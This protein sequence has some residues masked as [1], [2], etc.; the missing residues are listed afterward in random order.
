MHKHLLGLIACCLLAACGERKP[1]A[2][3]LD[4]SQYSLTCTEAADCVVVDELACATFC[5]SEAA[6]LRADD[7]EDYESRRA[8]HRDECRS[9]FV[10][11]CVGEDDETWVS[12]NI[13]LCVNE[14]CQ[15]RPRMDFVPDQR[16][17]CSSDDECFVVDVGDP[18]D[19]DCAQ[20][21]VTGPTGGEIERA[22]AAVDC[23]LTGD[24]TCT[25]DCTLEYRAVC[26]S[27]A[28][29]LEQVR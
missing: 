24:A 20:A 14:Q 1:E 8:E 4:L 25:P 23:G 2:V 19:C 26:R 28:C 15:V 10:I 27:G 5:D 29:G 6:P 11:D 7:L 22:R 16:Q 17:A 9:A 3:P 21:A 13:A 18:C 12:N